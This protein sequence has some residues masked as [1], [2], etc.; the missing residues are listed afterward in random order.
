MAC[1]PHPRPTC[2]SASVPDDDD[3]DA[4]DDDDEDVDQCCPAR[5]VGGCNLINFFVSF[6]GSNGT[7]QN[8]SLLLL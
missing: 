3:D 6:I 1:Q 5:Q 8:I 2:G 4:D 7:Y